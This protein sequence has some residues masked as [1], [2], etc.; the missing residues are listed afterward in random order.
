MP[1]S[2]LSSVVFPGKGNPNFPWEKS[3]WDNTF[4][5]SRGVLVDNDLTTKPWGVLVDNVL[6]TTPRGVLVDNDLTTTPWGVL[7]DN[8]LTTTPWAVLVDND[9]ITTPWGVLVD[10]QHRATPRE[11]LVDR[12]HCSQN[13]VECLLTKTTLFESIKHQISN[14]PNCSSYTK[15][16]EQNEAE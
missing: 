11:V 1:S 3:H 10:R 6:T 13:H 8:D 15:E 9:L 7:V 2:T 16:A 4:V 12:P 14:Q 5:T